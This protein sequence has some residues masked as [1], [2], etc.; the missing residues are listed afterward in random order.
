[1]IGEMNR[2]KTYIDTNKSKP[3]D[4]KPSKQ[5]LYLSRYRGI[6]LIQKNH[7]LPLPNRGEYT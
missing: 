2:V 7:E 4:L 6:R 5:D 3:I 1:M